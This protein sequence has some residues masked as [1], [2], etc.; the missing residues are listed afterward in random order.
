MRGPRKE[1]N[2]EHRDS[3]T[4]VTFRFWSYG[5]RRSTSKDCWC[6]FESIQ[7]VGLLGLWINAL[8]KA[9]FNFSIRTL[10]GRVG[11]GG[12]FCLFLLT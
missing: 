8:Q 7:G 10:R 2:E 6:G 5:L 3:D 1:E 4:F 11:W 12:G 9:L